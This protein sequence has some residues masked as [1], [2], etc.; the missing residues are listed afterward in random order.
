MKFT[1][2]TLLSFLSL[3]AFAQDM[4]YMTNPDG[5]S[6]YIG[7]CALH[8]DYKGKGLEVGKVVVD[9]FDY[10]SFNED[11]IEDFYNSLSP[12]TKELAKLVAD[13]DGY[14][15]GD[16]EYMLAGYYD[17]FTAYEVTVELWGKSKTKL[18]V[19]DYG[20]GG[21][22]GGYMFFENDS[23]V[24]K[25]VGQNFDGDLLY[26]DDNYTFDNNFN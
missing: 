21:G 25:L 23:G 19:V 20:V 15:D 5:T 1:L 11:D 18:T 7:S 2:L 16:E 24:Y 12:L 22:N 4:E 3:A 8:M 26:C 10:I 6:Q 13:T 14:F 9:S 17:D